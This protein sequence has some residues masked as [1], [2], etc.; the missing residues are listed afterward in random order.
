[1]FVKIQQRV[2]GESSVGCLRGWDWGAGLSYGWLPVLLD[3]PIALPRGQPVA[4]HAAAEAL[5]LCLGWVLV[6][7]RRRGR[8]LYPQEAPTRVGTVLQT[9]VYC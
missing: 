5:S 3:E 6:A 9:H 4:G 2:S 1:M 7:Q 8:I